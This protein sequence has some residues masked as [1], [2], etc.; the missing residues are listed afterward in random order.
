[1]RPQVFRTRIT[2]LLGIRHPI[3]CGGLMWLADARYVAA[4]VNAGGMGFVVAAPYPD[5][6]RFRDELR[7]CRELTA[8][9][10][11][12]VNLS[13]SRQLSTEAQLK[14]HVGIVLEEGIRFVETSG[15]SPEPILPALREAGIVVIHKVPAVRYAV[16]AERAGVDAVIIVGAECGG[17]PGTYMI[18]S[19]VQAADGPRR[20]RVPCVIGGGIGTGRQLLGTLAMGADGILMGSRMLVASELSA[21]PDYK[22]HIAAGDGTESRVV[23][24]VFR[25]HHRVL[26]NDAARAVAAL[27]ARK[28]E[29]FAAYAEHVRGTDTRHAYASGDLRRGMIDYGQ[30]VCFAEKEQSVEAIFDEIIDDALAA[31]DRLAATSA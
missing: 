19:M 20:L 14:R 11:F 13:I 21:H 3:L 31:R 28:V 7:L 15:S 27:E 12:G 1:M 22:A 6:E 26:D 17:H 2:D 24:Q 30:S 9:A 4:V 8:G 16:S 10:A 18:G 25:N 5:P 29:D 23:M